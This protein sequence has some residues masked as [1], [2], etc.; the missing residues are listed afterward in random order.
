[1]LPSRSSSREVR[2]RLP[3]FSVVY[4]SRGTLPTKKGS[5]GATGAPSSPCFHFPRKQFWGCTMFLGPA[6]QENCS[7]VTNLFF[8]PAGPAAAFPA[9]QPGALR[10]SPPCVL[11]L[12]PR[13]Q[14]GRGGGGGGGGVVLA[15]LSLPEL[16]DP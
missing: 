15:M 7:G 1:M 11:R 2:I 9:G 5:Q 14:V 16:Y 3:F 10:G 4:C 12:P 8:L 13:E 6:F